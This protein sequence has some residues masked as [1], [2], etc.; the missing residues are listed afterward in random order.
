MTWQ[1]EMDLV[2]S[3]LGSDLLCSTIG[4]IFRDHAHFVAVLSGY[5]QTGVVTLVRDGES[6]PSWESQELLRN[7]RELIG[8]DGISISLT[9][10]GAQAFENGTWDSL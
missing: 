1:P 10:K 2:D 9:D 3:L 8:L 6:L 4:P 5:V 7:A